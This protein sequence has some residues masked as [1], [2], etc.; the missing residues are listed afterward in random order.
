M[1]TLHIVDGE[2][3]GGTLR[4]SGIAR[5]KDILVWRDALYAGPVPA[6][7]T[8]RQLSR[9]RSQFWTKGK[10][11]GALRK[12]DAALTEYER[13]D[14]ISLWFGPGCT[15]CHLSL[16]QILSWLSERRISAKRLSWVAVHGGM[17]RTDQM[18]TAHAARQPITARQM[19]LNKRFWRDFRRPSPLGLVQMLAADLREVP[20]LR[21][22][23]AWLLREYPSRRNGL[24]RLED[25][26][27]RE[28]Q[29]LGRAKS[30]RAVASVVARDWVGDAFLFDVLR[31]LV[32]AK[33]PLL[34]FAEPYAGRIESW[35]FNGATLT[36]TA[37]GQGVL[38]NKQDLIA[39]NGI[40]RWI[41]GVHLQGH[42][43]RWRWDERA[44][45][46]ARKRS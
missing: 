6:G 44:R 45:T 13:Y 21:E 20:G 30:V 3:T 33:Y 27:L 46:L 14:E 43:V 35:K 11:P 31:N 32:S 28:I 17:L 40:D 16:A 38:S 9:L 41:G 23:V 12:R 42:N 19:Q 7:L 18:P 10:K 24:S 22:A 1:K 26:L 37:I 25:E 8:L 4:V 34:E 15:L 2:S 36:L 5:A 29:R 39:L